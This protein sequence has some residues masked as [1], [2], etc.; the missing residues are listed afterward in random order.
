MKYRLLDIVVCPHCKRRL[1]CNPL[2]ETEAEILE[3]TLA[4]DCG[5]WYPIISGIPRLLPDSL[6]ADCLLDNTNF[7]EKYRDKIPQVIG[8]T[9]VKDVSMNLKRRTSDS[10]SFE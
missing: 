5:R 8:S 9:I 1:T 4:C 10:F 2:L 7:L 3:G 6:K